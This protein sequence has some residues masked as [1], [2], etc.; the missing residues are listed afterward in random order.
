MPMQ[1]D[2]LFKPKSIAI[3]GAS[4]KPTIG[5]RLCASLD[6]IGFDGAIYPV[7]PNYATVAGRQCHASLADLPQAP[8]VA[9]FCV[10]HERVLDPLVAAAGRGVRGAVI[11]D[12]G[13]AERGDDGRR[14]Q[15]QVEGICREAG[16]AL[17]GPNCMGVLSPHDCST[18]YL[19]EL[20]DPMGLAGNVGIVSQSGGFCVSLLTDLRRFGF[21]H[22][23]SSGGEAVLVA[24]DY[25]EYLIDEPH[26]RLIGCFVE[27]L[28]QPERFAAALDRAA[29]AGTPVVV[30]KVGHSERTRHA[31]ATHTGG[32]AGDP[33]LASEL[34]RAHRAIEV[35]DLTAFTEVLAAAQGGT[36]PAGRRIAV[37]TSSGGLAELI[38]DIGASAGLSLPPLPPALR[39]EIEQRIGFIS[40]D[41]N[42]LDA[43]GNGAFA[44]NLPQALALLD[45]SPDHDIIV[46]GRDNFDAQPF[47]TPELALT[48]LELFTRAAAA[49]RKAHY[50]L[51]TRPGLMNREQTAHL[52]AKGIA[53]VGGIREGLGAIDMLARSGAAK[54]A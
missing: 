50:L 43:W 7:N 36:P 40:G 8:D 54:G 46:W 35:P 10:G 18:T 24:A 44:A 31:V 34:F 47:A 2:A 27:T 1:L 13:F 49:S 23:V 14:L 15:D 37:I 5:K 29:A 3:V 52:R 33:A 25:L 41:G 9:A 11:Y 21:S 38:L 19:Q 4:E 17:C 26:T 53:V 51:N 45:S 16:I 48:Y 22:V 30:L 39:A 42:P 20:R 32:N 12:G 6:R 28:R